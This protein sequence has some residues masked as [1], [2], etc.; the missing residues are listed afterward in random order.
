LEKYGEP[1]EIKSD[2]NFVTFEFQKKDG[3]TITLNLNQKL[4]E[5]RK[6]DESE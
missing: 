3:E 1:T 6:S 2:S 4:L 5:I